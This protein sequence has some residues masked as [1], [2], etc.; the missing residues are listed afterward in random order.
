MSLCI[1]L[2]RSMQIPEDLKGRVEAER[3]RQRCARPLGQLVAFQSVPD[4]SEKQEV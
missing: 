4:L 1:L 2:H 3:V